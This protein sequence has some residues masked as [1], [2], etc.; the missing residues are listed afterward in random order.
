MSATNNQPI[1]RPI[2]VKT[3][4][5]EW[6]PDS[7]A[8][9]AV[10]TGSA[11][12]LTPEESTELHRKNQRHDT[13]EILALRA[14]NKSMRARLQAIAAQI[15]DSQYY[16]KISPRG[17]PK[18]LNEIADA[19]HNTLETCAGIAGRALPNVKVCREVCEDR[20][21]TQSP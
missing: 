20:A 1:A 11:P 12:S 7:H 2:I 18:M 5:E 4:Q 14:Q 19:C 3:I 16:G 6:K 8:H 10:T 9:C 13:E 17:A 21:D 15:E